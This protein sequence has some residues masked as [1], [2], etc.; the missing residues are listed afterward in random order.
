MNSETSTKQTKARPN[1]NTADSVE[2]FRESRLGCPRIAR[3]TSS[4]ELGTESKYNFYVI[5]GHGNPSFR[6][7]SDAVLHMS[8]IECK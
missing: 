6:P 8:R 1:K 3:V 7:S 4:E 5:F 2:N